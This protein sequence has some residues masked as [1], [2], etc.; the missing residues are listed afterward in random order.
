M[1]PQAHGTVGAEPVELDVGEAVLSNVFNG[2][3][4]GVERDT[5]GGG[6][7]DQGWMPYRGTQLLENRRRGLFV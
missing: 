5:Q 4:G 3:S 2:G 1:D 6:L 7:P